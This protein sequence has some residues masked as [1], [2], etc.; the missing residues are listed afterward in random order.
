MGDNVTIQ[1]IQYLYGDSDSPLLQIDLIIER[2]NG[3]ILFER[4]FVEPNELNN[5]LENAKKS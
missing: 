2:T 5:L 3:E 4:L 1:E